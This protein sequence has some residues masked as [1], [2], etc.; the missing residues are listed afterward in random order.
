MN[1]VI[2]ENSMQVRYDRFATEPLLCLMNVT[3]NK[4]QVSC[5]IGY[6]LYK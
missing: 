2:R 5:R 4:A 6:Y 1:A 3:G